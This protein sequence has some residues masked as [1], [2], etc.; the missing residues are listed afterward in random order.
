MERRRSF[1]GPVQVNAVAEVE[2]DDE[3][4]GGGSAQAC[5]CV[6]ERGGRREGKEEKM[7]RGLPNP[8]YKEKGNRWAQKTRRPKKD[9]PA[10]RTPR[11]SGWLL[12][13]RIC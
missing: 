2:E 5:R 13:I 11:F 9:F 1:S 7:K 4:R 8:M 3:L 6:A 10:N 12:R